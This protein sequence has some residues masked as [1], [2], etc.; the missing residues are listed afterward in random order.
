MKKKFGIS[1]TIKQ[2]ALSSIFILA[3]LPTF[4]YASPTITVKELPYTYIYGCV[5]ISFL[6]DDPDGIVNS[7]HLI[8]D[9]GELMWPDGKNN[10]PPLWD[11][12]LDGDG[13]MTFYATQ[14]FPAGVPQIE[15]IILVYK[16]ETY[17]DLLG[18]VTLEYDKGDGG[19]GPWYPF[20][21]PADPFKLPLIPEPATL[22][23]LGLGGLILRKKI[24]GERKI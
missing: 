15:E 1:Q 22:L 11:G 6:I 17:D 7:L 8:P 14:T 24:S 19:N 10:I 3:I 2:V 5:A 18:S 20:D 21:P 16:K 12:G 4:L 23:L 13:C 9:H